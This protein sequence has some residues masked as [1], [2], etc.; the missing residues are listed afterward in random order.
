MNFVTEKDCA[1]HM[2]CVSDKIHVMHK[3]I[4][5]QFILIREEIAVFRTKLW[6][7]SVVIG[8]AVTALITAF[9][10]KHT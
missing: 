2:T 6:I 4:L 7:G 1:D 9:I 5:L 10:T 8:C 3:D